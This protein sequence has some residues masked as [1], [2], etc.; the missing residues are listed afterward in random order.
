MVSGTLAL[1]VAGVFSG[2]AVYIHIAV[3]PARLALD[4]A[5][6]LQEWQ[7]AYPRGM[8]AW[9]P[10]GRFVFLLGALSA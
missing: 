1:L 7:K 5:A 2:A 6:L 9:Y 8:W 10:P 4:H 3:Q